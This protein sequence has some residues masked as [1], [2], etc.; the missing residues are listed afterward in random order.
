MIGT[1][2]STFPQRI[3]D[4]TALLSLV[5]TLVQAECT[6]IIKHIE[7]GEIQVR[8]RVAGPLVFLKKLRHPIF[9]RPDE[10][11]GQESLKD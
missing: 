1:I 2:R 5:M 3:D 4:Q 6:I 10:M 9:V 7:T 11:K 8:R